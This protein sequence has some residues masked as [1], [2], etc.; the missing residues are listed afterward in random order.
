MIKKFSGILGVFLALFL[1]IPFVPIHAQD[2]PSVALTVDNGQRKSIVEF[3]ST[4]N[5]V[6]EYSAYHTSG[7]ATI[8]LFKA[9]TDDLFTYLTH[10]A[11]YHQLHQTVDTSKLTL[12]TTITVDLTSVYQ[13]KS[14]PLDQSGL[15]YI[16]L[17]M[18]NLTDEKFLIRSTFGSLAREAKDTFVVWN[19]DYTTKRSLSSGKATLYSFQDSAK[20][21]ATSN[22]DGDGIASLPLRSDADAAIIESQDSITF[23]PFNI[24]SLGYDYLWLSYDRNQTM[25]RYFIFTDRPIYRPGDTVKYKAVIRDDDDARYSIGSGAVSVKFT[26]LWDDSQPL[27][28]QT[29]TLDAYG[30]V[31]GTFK[32]PDTLAAG[33]YAI[34]LN[35]SGLP[36]SGDNYTSSGGNSIS[37]Q[38]ENYRKPEYTISA[39]SSAIDLIRGDTVNV[40]VKGQYFSG[41]PLRDTKVSYKIYASSYSYYDYE[42]YY[43]DTGDY[44]YHA[45]GGNVINQGEITFDSQGN[46]TLPVKTNENDS[47]G[48]TQAYFIEFSYTDATGNSSTT[49][50]NVLVRAGEFS[51]YR[52]GDTYSGQPGQP[53]TLPLMYKAFK[54]GVSLRRPLNLIITRHWWEKYH[55]DNYKYDQYQEKTAEIQKLTLDMPSSGANNLTFTPTDE[56]SYTIKASTTDDRGNYIEK[57][58]DLWISK[59]AYRYENSYSQNNGL[60]LTTDKKTYQPGDKVTTVLTSTIPD[61]DVFLAF[62]RGYQD[63]YQVVRLNGATATLT[64]PLA[65]HDLPNIYVVA[66]SFAADRL[67]ADSRNLSISTDSKKA[68]FKITTDKQSYAPG[69]EVAVHITATDVSGKPVSASLALWSVDKAIFE[70]S[71]KNYGSIFDTFWSERYDNTM[72][73]NS[74]EGI[75]NAGA[76]RGGCFLSGTKITLADGRQKNI[77]DIKVGDTVLSRD[78]Y[79]QTAA[80]ASRV[81]STH[82]TTAPGYVI[83]NHSL[84]LTPNHLLFVNGSWRQAG[85]VRVN[86][87]LTTD[88]NQSVTVTSVEWQAGKVAV[89]NLT[90]DTLHTFFADSYWVHNDKGDGDARSHFDDTAYWN[91]TV[92]TGAD[93]IADLRFKLPDN[94]TTWVITTIG[95][96]ADTRVGEAF[97]EIKTSQ[98]LVVRPV[99][100]NLLRNNDEIMLSALVHNYSP[101]DQVVTI[102]FKTDAGTIT[103]ST[104][105]SDQTIKAGSF[106]ELGWR[107]KVDTAKSVA[108][109]DFTVKDKNGHQDHVQT[110]LPVEPFGYWQPSSQFKSANFNFTVDKP[111]TIDPKKS[112]LTLDLSSNLFA[113]LP[114]ALRYLVNYPYGCVEQT[115]SA[116]VSKLIA[117]RYASQLGDS[118]S[119]LSQRQ[120][121]D[122]GVLLLR[123]LQQADGGWSWWHGASNDYVTAY[124]VQV[125]TEAKNQGITVD[126]SILN[127][128]KDY[129]L[130]SYDTMGPDAK[131]SRAYGLSFYGSAEKKIVD[132][133]LASLSDDLL[134]IA[135]IT[136]LRNGVFDAQRNGL[137]LL[138]SRAKRTDTA[139]YWSAGSIDKFGSNDASTALA[140]QALTQAGS[141]DQDVA[142]ALNYLSANRQYDYW[143][144]TFATSQV[145]RA[146]TAQKQSLTPAYTYQV[147]L[148]GL[149][150]ASGSFSATKTNVTLQ[151]DAAKVQKGSHLVITHSGSDPLYAT[152]S[153]KWWIASSDTAKVNHG[154]TID[155]TFENMKGSNYN[156][157][158]GDL[159][160][161]TLTVHS[162]Q[163]DYRDY[164]LIEDS[165]PSGLIPVNTNLENT[166]Q[167][168]QTDNWA[169]VY[170]QNGVQILF[171]AYNST[172]S[173]YARVINSGTFKA[174]PAFVTMMYHPD[175]WGRSD[176]VPLQVDAD[177]KMSPLS[178]INNFLKPAASSSHQSLL[179]VIVVLFISL[180]IALILLIR[181]RRGPPPAASA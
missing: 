16:R 7:S 122:Q 91:P 8:E 98:E 46:A 161:V 128:A 97:T 84:R 107:I 138:L 113:S 160:K 25:S 155:K 45:W 74:L 157:A 81:T 69:D 33:N 51:I 123:D 96:S 13:S 34:S 19:Q 24:R 135:V 73:D 163:P 1:I 58:F 48:K 28:T 82:T 50:V 174:P 115:T 167:D 11:K 39:V 76:E 42:Q 156:L 26:H 88:H 83:I 133:D 92:V 22:L 111:A 159:V 87:T 72:E 166:T 18:G 66:K 162:T 38:V 6:I 35:R 134:S 130:N 78:A 102:T 153:Q 68:Y 32:L 169:N 14:L 37:F 141:H 143:S 125:L 10:D 70:L 55:D 181:R 41:Y 90:I 4:Q 31:N 136:N 114:S 75:Y 85:S 139:L 94:L 112:L 15:Y 116:L 110:S 172:Y 119:D 109:M 36:V 127:K 49:G 121:I 95:A 12:V 61:R 108:S 29:L 175:V 59:D 47:Q 148:D 164:G 146:I 124:V 132:Q 117:A 86:D 21:L 63:R 23:I 101:Q 151:V 104:P 171:N 79:R 147:T 3:A 54:N 30:S 150:L 20:V 179:V 99:L 57:T 106:Q 129:L 168:L 17:K 137:N 93:G 173:Y 131:V 89:Y 126:P 118:L 67:D 154:L 152:F 56:G 62:E 44:Y 149:N 144:N 80:T 177:V 120:T 103:D 5:P 176:F 145:I 170:T 165:L 178:A 2:V 9:T 52:T 40:Q 71:D 105:T 142:S 158:P 43:P 53:I 100:P 140:I 77:E 60:S 180:S 27:A 65:D 64:L